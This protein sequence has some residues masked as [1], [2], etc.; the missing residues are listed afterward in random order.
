VQQPVGE[1]STHQPTLQPTRPP[2]PPPEVEIAG[3]FALP[4]ADAGP[5]EPMS[6]PPAS[7]PDA[8]GSGALGPGLW[9]PPMLL[10]AGPS[11]SSTDPST[12]EVQVVPAQRRRLDMYIMLD[13][14]ITLPATGVWEKMTEG[15]ETFVSDQRSRGTGVGIRYFGLTCT[16]SDYASPT[17]DVDLLPRN[18]LPIVASVRTRQPWSASPMLP[19]LR[20][21]IDHQQTRAREHP[22]WKQIVVLVSDGFTQDITCLYSTQDLAEAA[23]DGFD[24][25]PPIETHVVGVGVTTDLSQPFDEFITRLGAFNAI[26]EAGGSGQAITT[27]IGDDAAAFSDALQEVRRNAMPCEF[28]HPPGVAT[29]QLGVARY[30]NRDQLR[31]YSN[32][33]ACG[34]APG[35]YYAL[36]SAPT[37]ITLCPASCRWLRESDAN[38]IAL[39]LSCPAPAQP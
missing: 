6:V 27:S 26:A 16:A 21:G 3:S 36:E 17:I 32:K 25:E 14:N 18:R 35:W 23:R 29:S 30:P 20:G 28:E 2:E 1:Y 9:L 5:S 31:L 38:Q 11:S 10:D 33:D 19:A 12:C 37:P 4:P 34:S 24:S 8:A 13:S 15:L 7:L 22:A 39:V